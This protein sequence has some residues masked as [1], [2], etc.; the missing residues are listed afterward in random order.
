M[1][2]DDA[3]RI[4]TGIDSWSE[5]FF[6][7][8]YTGEVD[9]VRVIEGVEQRFMGRRD[10]KGKLTPIPIPEDMKRALSLAK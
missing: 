10:N 6:W 4:S 1:T 5:K 7:V 2:Y 8:A 9:G 3:L